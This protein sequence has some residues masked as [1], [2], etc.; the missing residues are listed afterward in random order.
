MPCRTITLQVTGH[1]KVLRFSSKIIQS[2]KSFA[3]PLEST[4]AMNMSTYE[5]GQDFH[6][7]SAFF[8][9]FGV[10]FLPRIIALPGNAT[11]F[12]LSAA[13]AHCAG[14]ARNAAS[15]IE[16]WEKQEGCV[17]IRSNYFVAK[18]SKL[19]LTINHGHA[20]VPYGEHRP[21]MCQEFQKQLQS[22]L[23][24]KIPGFD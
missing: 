5:V 14:R 11:K 3:Q 19:H 23:R 12:P 9:R 10:A 22:G 6:I 17:K 15:D 16:R 20:A 21:K 1:P 4:G 8:D 13:W 18:L 24:L 7:D 2:R